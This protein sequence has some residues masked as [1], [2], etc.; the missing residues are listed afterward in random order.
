MNDLLELQKQ[1][2]EALQKEL[3]R[4]NQHIAA[5]N[6]LI[7]ELYE[8]MKNEQRAYFDGTEQEYQQSQTV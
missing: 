6:K 5:A 3:E 7:N 8:A 4:K 2:I 1:Q